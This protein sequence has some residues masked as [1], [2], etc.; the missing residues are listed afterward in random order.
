MSRVP[1]WLIFVLALLLVLGLAVPVLADQTV[2]GTIKIVA[3]D[4]KE[5]VLTDDN[6]KEWTFTMDG[7]LTNVVA[8][9][10]DVTLDDLKTDDEVAVTFENADLKP[11]AKEIRPF[12]K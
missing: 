2:R 6:G 3:D 1:H 8:D 12:K 11:F 9:E 4:K 5:L 10:E 7:G